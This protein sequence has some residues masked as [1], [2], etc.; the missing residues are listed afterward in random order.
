MS[1]SYTYTTNVR[2]MLYRACELSM[3][4]NADT[5]TTI[6]IYSKFLDPI[7]KITQTGAVAVGQKVNTEVSMTEIAGSFDTQA[8]S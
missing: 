8:E 3:N 7:E 6:E 1:D 5:K 4:L 2:E